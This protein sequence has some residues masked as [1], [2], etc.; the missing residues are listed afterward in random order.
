MLDQAKFHVYVAVRLGPKYAV[1]IDWSDDSV[2]TFSKFEVIEGQTRIRVGW[3][4]F[5]KAR[6]EQAM[7]RRLKRGYSLFNFNCRTVSYL[8]L[9]KMGGFDSEEVYALFEKH[10]TLCGLDPEQCINPAEIRHFIEWE[11][12]Q[13]QENRCVIF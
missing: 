6:I 7:Q 8:L 4:D 12:R 11:Q 13:I 1:R 5:C 2:M 10:N 9:V 3:G